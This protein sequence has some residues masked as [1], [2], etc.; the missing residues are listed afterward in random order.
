MKKNTE[1]P[2]SVVMPVLITHEWQRYMTELCIKMMR[3]NTKLGFE[4]IIV[5]SFREQQR[6]NKFPSMCDKYIPLKYSANPTEDINKGIDSANGDFIVYTGND[7][8]MMPSWLE[9]MLE[10]F[11]I[12]DC[13]AATVSMAERGAFVGNKTPIPVICESH[14]GPLT[15]FKKGWRYD[16]AFK[17]Q[18][19]DDDLIMRLYLAGFRSYRNNRVVCHHLGQ[20]TWDSIYSDEERERLTK[21]SRALFTQRYKD[22]PLAIYRMIKRGHIVYGQEHII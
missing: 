22:C 14:Y 20:M 21:E 18:R 16:P 17:T 5:E 10:C 8:M 15:M 12:S 11:D 7:I 1:I 4:L 2:I 9:A 13:G 6:V 3:E 19:A